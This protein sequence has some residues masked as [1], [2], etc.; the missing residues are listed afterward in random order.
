MGDTICIRWF[1]QY[2]LLEFLR[3]REIS[4]RGKFE[5]LCCRSKKI[6]MKMRTK[7]QEKIRMFKRR[8]AE[9]KPE[10]RIIMMLQKEKRTIL[11]E[12]TEEG[13]DYD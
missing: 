11:E 13:D 4:F 8:I 5:E 12:K 7:F 9:V 2:G 6:G 1:Q 3:E 10:R